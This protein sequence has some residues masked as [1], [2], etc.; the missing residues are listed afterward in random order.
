MRATPHARA[1]WVAKVCLF[2]TVMLLAS[3]LFY[4][5]LQTQQCVSSWASTGVMQL[6]SA[7]CLLG[8][9]Q[10]RNF[11]RFSGRS[12]LQDAWFKRTVWEWLTMP[13]SACFAQNAALV[14]PGKLQVA[15]VLQPCSSQLL[16]PVFSCMRVPCQCAG[17][18]LLER[19]SSTVPSTLFG[20]D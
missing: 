14:S 12:I 4:S 3:V 18:V 19:L 8:Q 10:A 15:I 20:R 13:G 7:H 5:F 16:L 9:P 11:A 6:A 17:T 1:A 2:F